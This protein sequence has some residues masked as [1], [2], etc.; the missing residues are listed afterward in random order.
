MKKLKIPSIVLYAIPML[1]VFLFMLLVFYPGIMSP[2]AMV[3]WNQVQTGE[4]DNWHPAYVTIGIGLLTKIWNMPTIVII[5]QILIIAFV[6]SYALARLEKYYGVK[7]WFLFIISC[8]FSIT[9]LNFNLAVNMLKDTL[10]AIWIVLFVAFVIDIINDKEWIKNWKHAILFTLTILL[11]TLFRHNGI[12]VSILG[13]LSIIIIYRKEKMFRICF[14]FFVLSYIMMTTVGFKILHIQEANYAN[15]Y[16]PITH[17]FGR[18]L[19][20]EREFT[21]EEM[22]T[23]EKYV[24]TEQLKQNFS[25]YNMDYSIQTQNT[26]TLK[27]NSSEY[28]KLFAEKALEYPAELI[29]Q[30]VKLTSFFYSPWSFSES[31]VAGMF[32][33]T[34]LYIYE[35]IYPE[36]KEN[37]KLPDVIEKIKDV[38]RKYQNGALGIYTM[39]PAIYMYASIIAIIVLVVIKKNKKL[40]LIILPSLYNTLSLIPSMPVPSTRYVYI[41]FLTFWILVPWCVYEIVKVIKN[42][43]KSHGSENI[44]TGI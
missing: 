17:F 16:A 3:Q 19:V 2:D 4:I 13:M 7:R 32:T 36:L 22:R 34:E 20:N 31:Y 23:L 27:E 14:A 24:N 1:I 15:K 12:L 21:E 30:Y 44:N 18:L 11:I 25:Q 6:F 41:T 28:V 33:E 43:R 29:K 10:Y 42:K 39:R 8:L 38:T 35:D 26:E 5:V 9:P 37:S 40:I